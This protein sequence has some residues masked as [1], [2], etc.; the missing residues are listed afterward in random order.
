MTIHDILIK[1]GEYGPIILIFSSIFILSSK[2]LL[3][4]AYLVG[5]A[6]NTV[7]NLFLKGII[8]EP[9]P[10][11][12]NKNL[13]LVEQNLEHYFYQNGIPFDFY[14][15]PSGHAQDCLY[16][17]AFIYAALKNKTYLQWY[18]FASLLICF[19]R[20]YSNKHTLTQVICGSI[21]GMIC[22]YITYFTIKHNYK[23]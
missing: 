4:F 8:K 17:T 2:P 10:N 13:H 23:I 12:E 6:I 15:M 9:R 7:L 3:L 11:F 18:L 20:I 19:Q 14:G 21:I 1:I 22:G 5:L 16:S